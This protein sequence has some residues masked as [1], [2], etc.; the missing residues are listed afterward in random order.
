MS[1]LSMVAFAIFEPPS[2]LFEELDDLV[3]FVSFHILIVWYCKDIKF[4]INCKIF[5]WK[6]CNYFDFS[7]F[8]SDQGHEKMKINALM[9]WLIISTVVVM[10]Q[11]KPMMMHASTFSLRFLLILFPDM[12]NQ[13]LI[14]MLI[15]IYAM[16]SMYFML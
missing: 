6:F 9:V 3:Y 11:L 2:V 15:R 7:P 10:G 16:M 14:R 13:T 1:E 12:I 8:F 5:Q 4:Y